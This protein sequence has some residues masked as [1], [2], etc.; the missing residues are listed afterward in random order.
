MCY[1]LYC[2]DVELNPQHFQDMPVISNL[3]K[4]CKTKT[5][6]PLLRFICCLHSD[7][8]II[9]SLGFMYMYIYT[10]IYTHTYTLLIYIYIRNIGVCLHVRIHG[11]PWW[12]RQL[13]ICAQCER[14]KFSPWVGKIPWRREWLHIFSPELLKI[15]CIHCGPYL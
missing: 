15:K 10:Y 5:N 1:V 6:Y 3:Q 12:L 14:P 8:C 11:F 2:G 7:C 4:S 9:Y 13:R